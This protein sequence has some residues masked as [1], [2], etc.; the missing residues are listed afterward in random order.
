MHSALHA[1]ETCMG[2]T[3]GGHFAIAKLATKAKLGAAGLG[4]RA[5]V[6]GMQC[7]CRVAGCSRFRKEGWRN[8]PCGPFPLAKQPMLCWI[9]LFNACRWW[10]CVLKI[11]S[12][13]CFVKGDSEI[14]EAAGTH[15]H[16][17]GGG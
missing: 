12:I 1:G 14:L 16:S 3:R 6:V 4:V 17:S 15:T 13:A 7:S 11:F 9:L 10:C 2:A 5:H 8:R